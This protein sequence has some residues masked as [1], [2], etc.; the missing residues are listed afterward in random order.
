[1]PVAKHPKKRPPSSFHDDQQQAYEAHRQMGHADTSR[2]WEACARELRGG[3]RACAFA[4][5][6][7]KA[8]SEGAFARGAEL[9]NK[10][11]MNP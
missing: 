7:R 6:A 11:L 5:A 4:I 10:G 2:G 1:M 8:G 9:A 3:P